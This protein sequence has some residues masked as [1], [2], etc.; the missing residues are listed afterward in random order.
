MSKRIIRKVAKG[1]ARRRKTVRKKISGT[2]ERPRLAVFR[3]NKTIS[4]QVINDVEGATIASATSLEKELKDAEGTKTDVAKLVGAAIAKRAV[5]KGVKKV[6]F[7]R[8]G[9]KYHGRVQAL[10]DAARENGLEF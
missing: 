2:P 7:D 9:Y 8:S 1:R 10:A 4:C 5:D 3:A 6:V